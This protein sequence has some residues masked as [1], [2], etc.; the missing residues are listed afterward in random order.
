MSM[1]PASFPRQVGRERIVFR[2]WISRARSHRDFLGNSH[3]MPTSM[4]GLDAES[5]NLF[6][7]GL[8]VRRYHPPTDGTFWLTSL[9]KYCLEYLFAKYE[10]ERIAWLLISSMTLANGLDFFKPISR[11]LVKIASSVN[12]I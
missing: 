7:Q 1:P 12:Q 2:I 11:N 10:S 5:E 8:G 9:A 4:H 3:M 6:V